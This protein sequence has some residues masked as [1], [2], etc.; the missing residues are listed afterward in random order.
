M[1]HQEPRWYSRHSYGRFGR[2]ERSRFLQ[3]GLLMRPTT[4]FGLKGVY[5]RV[6]WADIIAWLWHEAGPNGGVMATVLKDLLDK[7]VNDPWR[8]EVGFSPDIQAAHAEL[9]DS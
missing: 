1:A 8:T 4:L 7:V 2:C 9:F 6:P 5:V 3:R